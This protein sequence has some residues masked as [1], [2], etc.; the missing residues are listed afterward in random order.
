MLALVDPAR[1][2]TLYVVGENQAPAAT[3][4]LPWDDLAGM[5]GCYFTGMTRPRS[6]SPAARVLVVTARRFEALA[7]SGV[8]ADA[9]VGSGR[10]RGEQYDLSRLEQRPEHVIVTGGSQGGSGYK[11]APVP[12]PVVDTYGAG[13]TFVAGVLF[14]LASDGRFRA[15][16]HTRPRARRRR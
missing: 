13:D 3:D 1:E 4:A 10:D 8:R 16:S 12:G 2:R 7:A 9:L 5:D 6:C 11:A 14:G 15:R